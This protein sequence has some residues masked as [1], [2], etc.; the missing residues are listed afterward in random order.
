M[1]A[2]IVAAEMRI[3]ASET[4]SNCSGGKHST[5]GVGACPRALWRGN[6]GHWSATAKTAAPSVGAAAFAGLGDGFIV[7]VSGACTLLAGV[8]NSEVVGHAFRRPVEFLDAVGAVGG[9]EVSGGWRRTT[10]TAT[11]TASPF[12]TPGP[13]SGRASRAPKSPPPFARSSVSPRRSV[14]VPVA[15]QSSSERLTAG[16]HSAKRQPSCFTA[17]RSRVREGD[18]PKGCANSSST[19][20]IFYAWVEVGHGIPSQQ[21]GRLGGAAKYPGIELRPA[22]G[23]ARVQ[24]TAA[25][26]KVRTG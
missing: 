5:G 19:P 12:S 22:G 18:S 26:S 8:I 1:V 4:P 6:L 2:C 16:W 13:S 10:L 7:P 14:F 15:V 9:A 24:V 11:R 21:G 17:S 20:S 23:F 25:W 3:R